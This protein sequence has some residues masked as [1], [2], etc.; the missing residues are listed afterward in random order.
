MKIPRKFWSQV[1]QRW[2]TVFVI[3]FGSFNII[4]MRTFLP[5]IITQ[6]VAPVK[7]DKHL[8]GEECPDS[9]SNNITFT[10]NHHA[11]GTSTRE[12]SH[13]SEYTQGIILSSFHWTFL[14][15]NILGGLIAE[16]YGGK[17]CLG[18]CILFTSVLTLLTPTSIHWGGSTAF[19]CIRAL[20][21]LPGGIKHPAMEILAAKWIPLSERSRA[22]TLILAGGPFGSVFGTTIAGLILQYV[23]NGWPI[24]FYAL[25]SLGFLSFFVHYALCYDKPSE[26]PYISHSEVQYLDENLKDIHDE[27]PATPWRFI[28]TSAP[29]WALII[30]V[31]GRSWSATTLAN[32]M[33]KYMSS[34]LKFSIRDNALFSSLPVLGSWVIGFFTSS[35]V[36]SLIAKNQMKITQVRKIGATVS[37]VVAGS[38]VIGASYAGCNGVLVVLLF[39]ISILLKGFSYSSIKLNMRDLSPNYVG[40]ITGLVRGI[41]NFSSIL[42]PYVVGIM[43]GNQTMSEWREVFWMTFIILF[44][45]NII[46]IIFGSGDLQKWNDPTYLKNDIELS[47]E[48]VDKNVK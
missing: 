35:I 13:W 24:V 11:N 22:Y 3:F 10:S 19:I 36:D 30:S 7:K 28:L 41:S 38:F 4:S 6:M 26:N 44:L 8:M 40:V 9:N 15:T 16:K 14:V 29:V 42:S 33:P 2:V 17:R 5:L 32:G 43:T 39:T 18:L 25:G 20:M 45:T 31:V 23:D 1:P 46:Y 27:K 21:G 48:A 34:V 47:K 12:L 37:S